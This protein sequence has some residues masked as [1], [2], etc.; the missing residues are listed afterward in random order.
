LTTSKGSFVRQKK[1][2]SSTQ[3][4][5]QNSISLSISIANIFFGGNPTSLSPPSS[6]PPKKQF[7]T[8]ASQKRKAAEEKKKENQSKTI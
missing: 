6:L 3:S 5:M 4:L 7:L 1:G 2:F 8:S